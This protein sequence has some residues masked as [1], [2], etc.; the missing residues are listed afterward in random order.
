[1]ARTVNVVAHAVRRDE[2]LDAA[3]RLMSAHGWERVSVQQVLGELSASKGAFYHYFDS[4]Q[5]LLDALVERMAGQ[6][7]AAL[8]PIAD[9]PQC[10]ALDKLNRFFAELAAWKAARRD[11]LVALLRVWHSD[12]NAIMRQKLRSGIADRMSPLLA[13]IIGHD[14]SG[15]V[16]AAAHPDR[17]ARLVVSLIQDLNEQLAI[18][19]IEFEDAT[20]DFGPVASTV[21]VYTEAL[22]RI[23]GLRTGSITL[24][25]IAALKAWFR[26]DGDRK[27]HPL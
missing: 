10:A 12:D 18:M 25:D 4:K 22:E 24:V 19:Y 26:P 3:Q 5:A 15:D 23:L 14:L 7:A 6:A 8:A 11:V 9:D 1:M 17:V 20:A 16:V 21:A 13:R 2:F 27:G